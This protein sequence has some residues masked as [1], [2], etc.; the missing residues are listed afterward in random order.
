[1]R[2]LLRMVAARRARVVAD[3]ASACADASSAWAASAGPGASRVAA[4]MAASDSDRTK[5]CKTLL[6]AEPLPALSAAANLGRWAARGRL[7]EAWKRLGSARRP[8]RQ[9]VAGVRPRAPS[10]RR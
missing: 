10:A 2:W 6:L 4:S 5:R 3:A 9:G 1:M 8:R 7:T